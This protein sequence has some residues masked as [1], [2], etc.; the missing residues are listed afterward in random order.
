M[1]RYNLMWIQC[2]F[3]KYVKM[4]WNSIY[5][6]QTMVLDMQ[7]EIQAGCYITWS[8]VYVLY[9]NQYLV[10]YKFHGTA[11]SFN[12]KICHVANQVSG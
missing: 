9:V 3:A 7:T 8:L 11:S 2:D 1:L 5:T 6:L 12:N 4:S 10:T